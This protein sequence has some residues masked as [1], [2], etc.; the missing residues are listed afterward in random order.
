MVIKKVLPWQSWNGRIY[1]LFYSN[2]YN[3]S[4]GCFFCWGYI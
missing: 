1:S 4:N 3:C 2:E